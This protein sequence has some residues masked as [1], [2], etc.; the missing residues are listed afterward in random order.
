[1]PRKTRRAVLLSSAAGPKSSLLGYVL[2]G[3]F[4]T[5]LGA[6]GMYLALRP[7]LKQAATVRVLTGDAAL[8]LGNAAFDQKNWAQAAA[9]KRWLWARVAAT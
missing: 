7:A 8:T 2:I 9:P 4:C 6:G 3:L 1:M 5:L